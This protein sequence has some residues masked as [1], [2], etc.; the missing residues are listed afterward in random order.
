MS[1][2]R[3]WATASRRRRSAALVTVA[4]TAFGAAPGLAC[5]VDTDCAV[6]D[7]TYRLYVPDGLDTGGP[8]GVLLFAHGYRGSAAGQM[9][10][11]SLR[12]L[13]DDLG[14][15]LA[16]LDAGGEDWNLAHRPAEPGQTVERESGYVRDVLDDL[17]GRLGLDPR[18]TVM[19]GFSAG[20]MMTWT[21]ACAM[22]GAFAGFVPMSG[23][24][25]L[26]PPDTCAGPPA[27]IVHIHGTADGVVPMAGRPIG[28]TRQGDV[29]VALAMY[30][31]FGE[32]GP[33]QR[34]DAPD[35]TVCDVSSNGAGAVLDLCTFDGGHG[36]SADRL[37]HGWDRVTGAD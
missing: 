1:A 22:P 33:P 20:G 25:W 28:R 9:R 34:G 16:T 36:F 18:R 17:D 3:P 8:T 13:A 21:I 7:R 19:S 37:R 2:V 15:A 26:R 14:V 29:G 10:N 35:G 24:Y 5:G 11:G 6:G 12:G 4:L 30:R 32:F 23:T 27:S 31:G